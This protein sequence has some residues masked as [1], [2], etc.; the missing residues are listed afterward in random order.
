MYFDSTFVG[1]FFPY[2]NIVQIAHGGAFFLVFFIEKTK[3][4]LQNKGFSHI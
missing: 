3:P 1:F 4:H 2:K